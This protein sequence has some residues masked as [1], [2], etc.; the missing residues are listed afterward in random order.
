[1]TRI[2]DAEKEALKQAADAA[3]AMIPKLMAQREQIDDRL[4]ALQTV[5]DAYAITSGKKPMR[6]SPNSS[7][8]TTDEKPKRAKKG[9]V[10][11]QIEIALGADALDVKELRDRLHSLFGTRFGRGTIYAALSREVNKKFIRSGSKWQN[12]PL[13]LAHKVS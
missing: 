11:E 7:G 13:L 8:S 3:S 5:V 4:K 9:Q 12:N 1:M 10:V 2:P 6:P